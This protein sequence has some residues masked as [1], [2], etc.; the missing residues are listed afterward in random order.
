MIKTLRLALAVAAPLCLGAHANDSEQV[1]KVLSDAK[2]EAAALQQDAAEL[3]AF[4]Q[5]GISWQSYA[6][7][8]VQIK[9]H[10][11]KVSAIVEELN[12]LRIVAA[13][14]QQIA[15]DRVNPLLKELVAN[16]ELT[17]TKLKDNPSRVHMPPYKEYVAA[18]YELATDLA[19]MIGDFVE[20]GKTKAKF[21]TL[22]RKLE[23]PEQ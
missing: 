21:E 22:A 8:L 11:N 2:A 15:I 7:N 13:R 9:T 3:R 20:Y 12:N 1:L 23:L 17:I 14:W 4:T 19:S 10:V 16:T 6:S 18:H 5:S